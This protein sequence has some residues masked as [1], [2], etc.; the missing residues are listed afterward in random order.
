M[1]A[2]LFLPT[3]TEVVL[4]LHSLE[5]KDRYPQRLLRRTN[6]ASSY[7]REVLGSLEASGLLEVKRSGRINRLVLT[8]AGNQLVFHLSECRKVLRATT[9]R[10]WD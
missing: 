3:W 6:A 9:D 7:F 5:P 2:R 1:T 4:A 8:A 10:S